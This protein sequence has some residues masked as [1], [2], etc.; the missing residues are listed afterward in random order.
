MKR[1]QEQIPLLLYPL[2]FAALCLIQYRFGLYSKEMILKYTGAGSLMYL[3]PIIKI[4]IDAFSGILTAAFVVFA[5]HHRPHWLT[6]IYLLL[7]GLAG[8]V[9]IGGYYFG[10]TNLLSFSATSEFFNYFYYNRTAF[11]IMCGSILFV[12]LSGIFRRRRHRDRYF[13]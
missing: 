12:V 10:I 7:I 13:Y 1:F 8:P 11:G 6:C 3:A 9:I 4:L 2:L 5:W